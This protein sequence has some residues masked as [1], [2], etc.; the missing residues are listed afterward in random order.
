MKTLGSISEDEIRELK[1]K[2]DRA[3]IDISTLYH[4]LLGMGLSE[5]EAK[6]LTNR[7][8]MEIMAETFAKSPF[9]VDVAERT[10]EI[11]RPRSSFGQRRLPGVDRRTM[12]SRLPTV[13]QYLREY[14][15][16]EGDPIPFEDIN[17]VLSMNLGFGDIRTRRAY[18]KDLV[19]FNYLQ[20]ASK[21]PVNRVSRVAKKD[22]TSGKVRIIDYE[23]RIGVKTY[24]FGARAPRS[25]Q[26]TLNPKYLQPKR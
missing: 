18:I 5:E 16:K 1:E 14:G 3:E 22:K 17:Y 6:N 4:M 25:H 9:Y 12:L 20:E 2:Y 10:L 26:E 8:D 15:F 23:S 21:K 7:I 13:I 24:I 11:A 19:N